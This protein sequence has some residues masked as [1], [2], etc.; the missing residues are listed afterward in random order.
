MMLVLK[1]CIPINPYGDGMD[2][3]FFKPKFDFKT[4]KQDLDMIN[5][6]G[7]REQMRGKTRLEKMELLTESLIRRFSAD[8]EKFRLLTEDNLAYRYFQDILGRVPNIKFLNT[9]LSEYIKKGDTGE[10]ERCLRLGADPNAKDKDGATP[11]MT[12][13]LLWGQ[14]YEMTKLLADSGGK[15]DKSYATRMLA[16]HVWTL[17]IEAYDIL[18]AKQYDIK[19][20]HADETSSMQKISDLLSMGAD[21]NAKASLVPSGHPLPA[22]HLAVLGNNPKCV[23][24]ILGAPGLDYNFVDEQQGTA[25]DIAEMRLKMG[26]GSD[27]RRRAVEIVAL[28]RVNGCKT[29]QELG[30][31]YSPPKIEYFGN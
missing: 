30:K 14:D 22:L 21:V 23:K 25:L 10:A 29:A 15:A 1:T 19:M 7:I 8:D 17:A 4:T 18:V 9:K 5:A 24:L 27:E 13:V 3:L 12:A 26:H 6:L 28:L 31:S 16:L 11:Y 2:P 20:Q